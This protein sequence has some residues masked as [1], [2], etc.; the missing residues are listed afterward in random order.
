M[1]RKD[2]EPEDT[3]FEENH[4]DITPPTETPSTRGNDREQD[5][6]D[7]GLETQIE[8][9]KEQLLR[10]AAE[11]ENYKRRS[12]ETISSLAKTANEGLILELLSVIDDFDRSLKAGKEHPDWESFYEGVSL[13]RNKLMKVLQGRGLKPIE[14][15]GKPFDLEYHHAMMQV[16]RD[17]VEPD[18]VVEE[19]EKGYMMN[20]KVLRHAKVI[21]SKAPEN[22]IQK[23][24]DTTPVETSQ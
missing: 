24:G 8:K 4:G 11:F 6:K 13:V 9:L 16:P 2:V 14:S 7:S 18:T 15:V 5:L 21:V 23:P 3:H 17:D 10:K 20:E 12:E 22:E 1:N 19:L